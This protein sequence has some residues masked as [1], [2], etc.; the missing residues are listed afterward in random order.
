[1]TC[2]KK[3]IRTFYLYSIFGLRVSW[4]KYELKID[5]RLRASG[6]PTGMNKGI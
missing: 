3:N 5:F 4:F 1:M 2:S 6:M